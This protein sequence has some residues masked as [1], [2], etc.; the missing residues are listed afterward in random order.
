MLVGCLY[1]P[2]RVMMA[3]LL[4]L[5]PIPALAAACLTAGSPSIVIDWAPYR[6][7]L[8]V[9]NTGAILLGAA[10]LLWIAAGVYAG[11]YLREDSNRERF[12]VCWLLTLT[13]SIGIFL[14]ADIASFLLFYALV[15]L[16]AYGMIIHDGTSIVASRRFYLHRFCSSG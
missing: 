1:A 9:D 8:A 13:G 12:T 2:M 6:L 15:S 7:I 10:A 11:D 5:A 3:R 4:W 14:A 16:P